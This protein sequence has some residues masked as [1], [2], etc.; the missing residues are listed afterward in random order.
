MT[1]RGIGFT[2]P[3]A[4]K[5]GV[6]VVYSVPAFYKNLERGDNPEGV[7]YSNEIKLTFLEPSVEEAEIMDAYWAQDRS[8]LFLGDNHVYVKADED[9]LESLYEQYAEYD[10][11]KYVIFLLARSTIYKNKNTMTSYEAVK[12]LDELLMRFPEFRYEEV[13]QHLGVAY[14][15]SGQIGKAIEVYGNLLEGS[16][17]MVDNYTFMAEKIAAE[18]PR[19]SAV[20]KWLRM[21]A[22]GVKFGSYGEMQMSDKRLGR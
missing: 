4:G 17:Y 22:M 5:Y 14:A 19:G 21:R 7:I 15:Y 18:A 12:Y 2:F 10:L 9:L 16:P 13:R 1:P 3:V 8:S 11:I 6:R 20:T